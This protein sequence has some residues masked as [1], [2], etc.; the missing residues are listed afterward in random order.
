MG[1][2]PSGGDEVGA[3]GGGAGGVEGGPVGAV[4][5]DLEDGF[6][7]GA[8][9]EPVPEA[10]DEVGGAGGVDG[11]GG[12]LGGGETLGGSRCCPCQGTTLRGLLL[13]AYAFGKVAQI[14]GIAAIVSFVGGGILLVLSILGFVHVQAGRT[15]DTAVSATSEQRQANA[16]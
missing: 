3:V 8:D 5:G 1:E 10:E 12:V 13:N 15:R 6:G 9:F 11:E 2:G 14:A 7:G 16:A 4:G